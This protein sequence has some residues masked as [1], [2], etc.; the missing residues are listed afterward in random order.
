MRSPPRAFAVEVY[1]RF[2]TTL[3]AM[4]TEAERAEARRASYRRYYAANTEMCKFRQ[5]KCRATDKARARAVERY[6]RRRDAI[7][8]AT[9]V[10]R[11]PLGRP[12]VSDDQVRAQLEAY[13]SAARATKADKL[14]TEADKE[15]TDIDKGCSV[16]LPT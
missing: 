1:Q 16:A 14:A 8:E 4:P 7:A 5:L 13:E 15:A 9:G 12:R 3:S 11:R 2:I 10:P 6:H